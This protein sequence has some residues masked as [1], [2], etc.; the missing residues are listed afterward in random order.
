MIWVRLTCE[1]VLREVNVWG[2]IAWQL[3][4]KAGI[5]YRDLRLVNREIT[6][7][8]NWIVIFWLSNFII[9]EITHNQ[10]FK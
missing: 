7:L 10:K 5:Q 1:V 2:G 4:Q 9:V 3:R 8:F 6:S